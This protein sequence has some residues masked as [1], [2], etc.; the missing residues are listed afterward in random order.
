M[1]RQPAK[2]LYSDADCIIVEIELRVVQ[3]WGEY[4]SQTKNR[5]SPIQFIDTLRRCG[6]RFT[7]INLEVRIGTCPDLTLWRDS[8]SLSHLIDQWSLLQIPINLMVTVPTASSGKDIRFEETQTRWLEETVLMC[9][10]KER[11]VG[12]YYSNWDQQTS[13]GPQTALVNG[14]ESPR[15][16]LDLL[17]SMSNKYWC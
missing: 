9:L 1:Q 17:Q 11:V 10:A 16:I 8:L 5:L 14:D 2:R 15:C 13:I 7:E 3:P 12:I 4:L 6:V